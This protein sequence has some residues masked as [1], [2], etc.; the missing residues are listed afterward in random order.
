MAISRA[1]LAKGLGLVSMPCLAWS[2]TGT[3]TS[4]PKSSPTESSDRA[5]EEEVMLPEF[6]A[7]PTKSEGSA[8]GDDT[9]KRMLLGLTTKPLHWRFRSSEEAVEDN[10]YDRLSTRYTLLLLVQWLHQAG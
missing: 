1:Q 7:A 6:G 3:K 9:S 4:T 2:T 8:I 5:F 10:L